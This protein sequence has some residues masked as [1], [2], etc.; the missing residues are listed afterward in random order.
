MNP[1]D[2][3]GL[4][5]S[6]PQGWRVSKYDEWGFYRNQFVRQQNGLRAVDLLVVAADDT[7]YLIEV[8]DYRNPSADKPSDLPSVLAEKVLHTL[9]AMLPARL[10]ATNSAESQMASAVL[11]A[12]NLRI[13]LHVEQPRRRIPLIDPADLQQKLKRLVR[14]IDPH[15]KVVSARNLGKLPWQVS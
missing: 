5:F 9:A 13:I 3:D 7:A 8:K 6:F 12:K 1:L 10:G 4:L 15:V 14:A 2:V 11:A